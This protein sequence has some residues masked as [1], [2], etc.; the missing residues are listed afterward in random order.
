MPA[1]PALAAGLGGVWL[2]EV[3]GWRGLITTHPPPTGGPIVIHQGTLARR[4]V[5][6]ALLTRSR[7]LHVSVCGR[8]CADRDLDK[9]IYT[10]R[11]HER[12]RIILTVYRTPA[13][14]TLSPSDTFIHIKLPDR[15]HRAH[16]RAAVGQHK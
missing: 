5:A 1:A 9:S 13:T 15:E 14:N 16:S 7:A 10:N 11:T 8:C 4:S 3:W 2:S 6:R 12:L